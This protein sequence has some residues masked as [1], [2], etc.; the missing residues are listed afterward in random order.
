MNT[1]ISTPFKRNALL[2]SLCWLVATVLMLLISR[3]S[4]L[5]DV[6]W[7]GDTNWFMTCGRAWMEGLTPYVDFA[8]SKGPLLWLIYGVGYLISPHDFTG[9]MW[10]STLSY[11]VVFFFSFKSLRLLG[12]NRW[13][14]ACGLA[15]I[16]LL[17]LNGYVHDEVRAEDFSQA[18]IAPV[19]YRFLLHERDNAPT[20]GAVCRSAAVLGFALASTLLIKYSVTLMLA[21]FI[22]HA[23]WV[24]PRRAR[25]NPLRALAWLAGGALAMLLPWVALMTVQGWF[26]D[27]IREYFVNTLATLGNL[28]QTKLSGASI[29]AE[30][31]KKS[32]LLYM[33]VIFLALLWHATARKPRRY[34]LLLIM[35]WMV[36]VVMINGKSHFYYSSLALMA[37][38]GVALAL[39]RL[40]RRVSTAALAAVALLALASTKYSANNSLFT[41][42][43]AK[44][45]CYYYY[46][47]LLCQVERPRVLYLELHDKGHGMP[48][49]ALPACR[50]W[51]MQEGGTEAMHRDQ[52]ETACRKSPDFVFIDHEDSLNARRLEAWG[53]NR[54]DYR[55]HRDT[56]RTWSDDG[57]VVLYSKQTLKDTLVKVTNSDVLIKR[58]PLNTTQKA[59][60]FE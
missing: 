35:G 26:D 14:A 57:H 9:V 58:D 2:L 21:A 30:A 50:Y 54:Y 43:L 53:Y 16:A 37:T 19:L 52:L 12:T 13:G 28:G 5:Y 20:A 22:P 7:R 1:S 25:L 6:W 24:F 32:L 60:H 10:L 40:K 34:G 56:V 4:Y 44:R 48:A 39:S 46:A 23:M 47:G 49:D 38:P 17:M 41:H 29:V 51:A 15:V 36:A 45:D 31:T 8:D 27:F 18:F 59:H 55:T 33:A 11:A 42:D 3:D